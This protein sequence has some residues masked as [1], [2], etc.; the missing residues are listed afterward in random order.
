MLNWPNLKVSNNR[1]IN[2]SYF[3]RKLFRRV[4]KNRE[5]P[6]GNQK[7]W[8]RNI[9][10]SKNILTLYWKNCTFV[11]VEKS[12]FIKITILHQKFLQDGQKI[13]VGVFVFRKKSIIVYRR[14]SSK[15]VQDGRLA[16]A[17][18]PPNKKYFD[19]LLQTVKIETTVLNKVFYK[20]QFH[21]WFLY[22]MQK[23]GVSRFS[24]EKFLPHR[25]KKN[26]RGTFLFQ[27]ISRI[28]K[29]YG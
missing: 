17:Y 12:G 6:F 21:L 13:S 10:L 3:C 20:H 29:F 25:A 19:Q 4:G 28:E 15:N 23:R 2:V 11:V 1:G 18:F 14:A 7:F 26:R 22:F 27:K 24:V 8:F 9:F 16:P 5:G